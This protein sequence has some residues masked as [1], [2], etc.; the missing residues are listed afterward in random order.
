MRASGEEAG[1]RGHK[2]LVHDG[3]LEKVLGQ[4]TRIQVVVI[5][6]ADSAQEAHWA[7]PAELKV[8]HAKHEALSL[9]NLLG[10]VAIVNHEDDFIHRRAVDFLVLGCNEQG[11]RANEL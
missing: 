2:S 7:G 10:G 6:L 8:E 1:R 3:E 5:S 11:R 9:E 4:R